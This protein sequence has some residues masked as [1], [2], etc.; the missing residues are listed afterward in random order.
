M[1]ETDVT[2]SFKFIQSKKEI[3]TNYRVFNIP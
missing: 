1:F 2:P 3:S